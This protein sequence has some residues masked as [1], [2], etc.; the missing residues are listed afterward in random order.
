M[1][2][3]ELID[4][5]LFAVE[6]HLA[7]TQRADILSELRSSLE[8]ALDAKAEGAPSEGE[9]I[10]LLKQMGHP[11]KVAASYYPEGQYLIGPA[12]YPFFQ[13]V[14]GIALSA[15]IGAQLLVVLISLLLPSESVSIQDSLWEILSSVPSVIGM[16]VLVFVLLQRSDVSLVWPQEE[17]WD[18]A[19]LP[20]VHETEPIGTGERL[21]DILLSTMLLV[22]LTRFAYQDGFAAGGAS[23][24]ANPV[25]EQAFPW[26]ALAMVIGIVLDIWLLWQGRWTRRA[27]L[28]MIGANLFDIAVLGVLLQGQSGWLADRG[29]PGLLAGVGR[30]PELLR[31]DPQIGGMVIFQIVFLSIL[32]AV[33]VETAVH[34]FRLFHSWSRSGPLYPVKVAEPSG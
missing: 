3:L 23:I 1:E 8:D 21:F 29:L 5:Y 25:V 9:V 26:I 4:R 14:A 24:L 27:R 16:V 20:A 30:I 15:T 17:G 11:R 34:L 31:R 32:I 28:L 7:P 19:T 2:P 33:L 10:A 18:P 6:R 13:M 12:L 22:W